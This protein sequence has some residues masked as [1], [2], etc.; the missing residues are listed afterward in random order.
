MS[1]I[2][3]RGLHRLEGEIRIQGSK[4][5]VLPVMAASLLHKGTVILEN[6]PKIQD[7]FCMMGILESL[8]CICRWKEHTLTIRTD[9]LDGSRIPEVEARKMRSSIMLMGPLL[10]RMNEVIGWYPGGCSIGERP[11]DLHLA[12]FQ[13]MGAEIFCDGD[14]ITAVTEGIAGTDIDL[15]FPS[16]GATENVIMA[17]AAAEGVTTL[18]G[19]AREPE[20]E[21]LC[22]FLQEMG[23]R[24]EGTGSSMLRIH[25]GCE[26][27]DVT[28]RVPGDRI[29]A[30]T[31]LGA[32][33][34]AGGDVFLKDAPTVHLSEV[35]DAAGQM[36]GE[37]E[38]LPDGIR[39]RM[40]GRPRPIAL[41]TGVYPGFP[42][43]LQSVFVAA[44][45][46]ADGTSFISEHVFEGRFASAKELRKLGGHI[47]I[48]DRTVCVEGIY[49]LSGGELTA[50]DL[51]GGAALVVAGL[52]ARGE[53]RVSGYEHIR[54]GYEDICRDLRGAGADI[55]YMDFR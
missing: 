39:L 38:I 41:K 6:V 44:A 19:A 36:G 8:G 18:Y 7:V 28:F 27:H 30:G 12:A 43:D 11:I 55:E 14:R 15:Q 25:G 40:E 1:G 23:V 34:A 33:L 24:I 13:A 21:C 46:V 2:L 53:T 50:P 20:I 29:V 42:T 54:R 35:L 26:L 3:I 22:L 10:G 51:R 9:G 49:P 5:A 45:A 31:Y 16:V 52:A 47:I 17:A 37:F 32:I 4:N 48:K